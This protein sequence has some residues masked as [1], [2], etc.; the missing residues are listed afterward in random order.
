[1]LLAGAAAAALPTFGFAQ[2]WSFT[3]AGNSANWTTP[4]NWNP[5]VIYPNS[6][7][8][9]VTFPSGPV[10]TTGGTILL[11]NGVQVGI[12]HFNSNSTVAGYVIQGSGTITL[13]PEGI[14]QVGF[15]SFAGSANT[16]T[17]NT[18]IAMSASNSVWHKTGPGTLVLGA[19]SSY[20]TGGI[21]VDDGVVDVQN[22]S[23]LT[24]IGIVST[25]NNGVI[26]LNNTTGSFFAGLG[27]TGAPAGGMLQ[28]SGN[29]T[30]SGPVF[31]VAANGSVGVDPGGTLTASGGILDGTD[32]TV[33]GFVKMGAGT[34][35][36]SQFALN[37]ALNVSG[38]RA[39]LTVKGTP[40]SVLST[41]SS[42]TI[43]G[44]S[45][46]D[47]SNNKM[48]VSY[49]GTSPGATIRGYLTSGYN[50]GAWN[51]TSGINSSSGDATNFAIAYVD[52]N[53]N[54]SNFAHGVAANQVE[55]LFTRYGDLNLDGLVNSA[56]ASKFLA[57]YG[58]AVTRWID[59]DL[60]Y[61]GLVNSADA[62]KFLANYGKG[63]GFSQL[64]G[65]TAADASAFAAIQALVPEPATG[66]MVLG[67][68]GLFAGRRRR[69][70]K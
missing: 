28:A 40:N 20:S 46:L 48:I 60:N 44:G 68:L 52:G 47:M 61:D 23:A 6:L 35:V 3:F 29:N 53:D 45:A 33:N 18:G 27:S 42:L 12:M 32:S 5:N 9:E 36:T 56:D 57:N 49:T 64:D 2:T 7:S 22:S 10:G 59:G 8:A 39:K 17:I 14:I 67:G 13:P 69:V 62:S 19:A 54:P 4:L 15:G 55:I 11:D 21:S 26:R 31:V 25:S 30:I 24:G 58:K 63:A 1:M 37:G 16:A 66:L 50:G 38:G 70:A 65:L 41:A 51:G 43:A 34:L